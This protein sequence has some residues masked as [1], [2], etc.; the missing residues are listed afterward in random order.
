MIPHLNPPD[1]V[2]MGVPPLYYMVSC[3]AFALLCPPA[4][5]ANHSDLLT[6]C[7][8]ALLSCLS[9]GL[10]PC[11]SSCHPRGPGDTLHS[12][13]F[14][15]NEHQSA[16]NEASTSSCFRQDWTPHSL[17]RRAPHVPQLLD[18]PSPFSAFLRLSTLISL[19]SS[20]PYL[21]SFACVAHICVACELTCVCVW[22]GWG[23]E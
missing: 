9:H 19:S 6:G 5:M 15:D 12:A 4:A 10:L 2:P 11:S 1:T 17:L 21:C 7:E 13:S 3:W 20:A 16:P 14:L 22:G 23:R 18:S 8:E